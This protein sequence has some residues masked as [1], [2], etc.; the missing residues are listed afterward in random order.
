MV[1]NHKFGTTYL[2]MSL[3]GV[4]TFNQGKNEIVDVQV[5]SSGF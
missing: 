3:Y 2:A 5:D 4:K 1:A